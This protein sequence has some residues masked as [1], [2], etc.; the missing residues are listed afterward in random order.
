ML[1]AIHASDEPRVQALLAA[2]AAVVLSG[3]PLA[4]AVLAQRQKICEAL[5]RA[6]AD[7]LST[8]SGG[9]NSIHL[10]A[11]TGNVP[12][13]RLVLSAAPAAV[14]QPS[15]VGMTALMY[16]AAFGHN[17]ACELLLEAGADPRPTDALGR[18]ATVHASQREA[19]LWKQGVEYRA[20]REELERHCDELMGPGAG[21]IG[22][23]PAAGSERVE[24]VRPLLT[25]YN[26]HHGPEPPAIPLRRPTAP[27]ATAG[28][29][30]EALAL[31]GG[32]DTSLLASPLDTPLNS[33]GE[34]DL[35]LPVYASFPFCPTSTGA[36][37]RGSAGGRAAGEPSG[38]QGE[39]MA[40]C[41]LN[42][43]I[44]EAT[45]A[46]FRGISAARFAG[47][48]PVRNGGGG[49][50]R[51]GSV[52]GSTRGSVFGG[53]SRAGPRAAAPSCGAP[54][55][56][57]AAP[58]AAASA[59]YAQH[60]ASSAA[61]SAR[62]RRSSTPARSEAGAS[63]AA[64]TGRR[65]SQVRGSADP[66]QLEIRRLKESGRPGDAVKLMEARLRMDRAERT[67]PP[68]AWRT[69]VERRPPSDPLA[70]MS[71]SVAGV[72]R[73]GQPLQMQSSDVT[74]T[75]GSSALPPR[76]RTEWA[77]HFHG[78]PFSR[79]LALGSGGMGARLLAN[80][81]QERDIVRYT[82]QLQ[83]VERAQARAEGL[84]PPCPA[85]PLS[86]ALRERQEALAAAEVAAEA[87]EQLPPAGAKDKPPPK[88]S[89]PK[90]K[91]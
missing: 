4:L 56:S 15:A 79:E 37:P 62:P 3:H 2:E 66:L 63:A 39:E 44:S 74:L 89:K 72:R 67:Q 22:G 90:G 57:S 83:L 45:Y 20:W 36:L 77:P 78:A 71:T 5:Q 32:L 42:T 91:K 73:I 69:V 81:L 75:E 11:C 26:D 85:K 51:Y 17:G 31:E 28:A 6:G 13:L 70:R 50:G 65:K 19:Y 41:G 40:A 52:A 88:G 43:V 24:A 7:V 55:S 34:P 12:I 84:R 68:S 9:L 21:A 76:A 60:R 18:S 61:S 86:Q 14:D 35:A 29:P 8:T 54:Y 64:S 33:R 1:A 23:V 80:P 59:R 47:A 27:P 48:V 53:S 30:R 10:A 58:S 46:G 38:P 16:A 82:Q 87:A 25:Y 49:G